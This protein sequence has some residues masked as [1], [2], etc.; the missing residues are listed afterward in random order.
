M[1]C[2]RLVLGTCKLLR[3]RMRLCS[4]RFEEATLWLR[5]HDFWIDMSNRETKSMEGWK[6]QAAERAERKE[7]HRELRKSLSALA[8]LRQLFFFWRNKLLWRCS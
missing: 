8:A 7:L 6:A 4:A 2:C 5:F 1:K 3:M